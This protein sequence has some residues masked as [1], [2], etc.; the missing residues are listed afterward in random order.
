[1]STL[2]P[3]KKSWVLTLESVGF[4]LNH[5]TRRKGL[6]VP[7]TPLWLASH[8]PHKEG[9]RIGAPARFS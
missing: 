6:Y 7:F 4:K 1:M 8:L 9:D 2:F 3:S 5:S